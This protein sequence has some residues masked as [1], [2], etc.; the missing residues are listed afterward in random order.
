MA[1]GEQK[2]AFEAKKRKGV[3][4]C[5]VKPGNEVLIGEPKNKVKK[6]NCLQD[7]HQVPFTITSLTE[8]GVTSVAMLG[9]MQKIIAMNLR[10]AKWTTSMPIM[11]HCGPRGCVH[12]K[13]K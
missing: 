11:V 9:N 5:S 7:L 4:Q 8:K 10:A 1:Q 6:E 12:S 13:N 2:K 3:P